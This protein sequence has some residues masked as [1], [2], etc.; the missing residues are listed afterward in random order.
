MLRLLF[1]L[2]FSS[3]MRSVKIDEIHKC[4]SSLWRARN[5]YNVVKGE[6]VS[7]LTGR[8]EWTMALE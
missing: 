1:C 2:L 8:I 6:L 3:Q 7:R 5:G 4:S